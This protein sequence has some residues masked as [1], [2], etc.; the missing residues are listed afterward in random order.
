M[1]P[2][3]REIGKFIASHSLVVKDAATTSNSAVAKPIG[4]VSDKPITAV[5][6][7][8][9]TVPRITETE[10]AKSVP[11]TGVTKSETAVA[12]TEPE[13]VTT[14]K[15]AEASTEATVVAAEASTIA[16]VAETSTITAEAAVAVAETAMTKSA[17]EA[18]MAAEAATVTTAVRQCRTLPIQFARPNRSIQRHGHG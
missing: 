3:R 2:R 15:T 5:A 12:E 4:V 7:T 10:A 6:K 13:S 16:A 1:P 11:I 14:V 9:I 8:T 18:A 17:A